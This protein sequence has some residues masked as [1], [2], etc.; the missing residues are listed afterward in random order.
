ML[1]VHKTN[2][3]KS[4]IPIGEIEKLIPTDRVEGNFE[5]VTSL[6]KPKEAK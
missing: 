1:E 6:T 5:I 3:R 2:K 4:I